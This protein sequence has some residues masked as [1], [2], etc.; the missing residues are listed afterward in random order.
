MGSSPQDSALIR[1]SLAQPAK[2]ARPPAGAVD[3]EGPDR[4]PSA[5]L[6][7]NAPTLKAHQS[8]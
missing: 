2:Y 7:I 1:E 8:M 4:R 6:T 3:G 5:P